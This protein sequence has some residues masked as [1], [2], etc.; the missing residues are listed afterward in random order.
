MTNTDPI[1]LKFGIY[2]L[3]YPLLILDYRFSQMFPN[4]SNETQTNM[5]VFGQMRQS[6]ATE[7][8]VTTHCSMA[9]E[10]CKNDG[11]ISYLLLCRPYASTMRCIVLLVIF[12]ISVQSNQY[13]S[14]YGFCNF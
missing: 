13:L 6:H 1:E 8:R 4:L 12:Q 10:W 5:S 11:I 2:A 7:G 3:Y 9:H 14:F